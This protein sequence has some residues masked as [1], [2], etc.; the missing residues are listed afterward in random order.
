MWNTDTEE[1]PEPEGPGCA[2][3]NVD[4]DCAC[5]ALIGKPCAECRTRVEDEVTP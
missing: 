2:A 4:C 5:H 1:R 3:C